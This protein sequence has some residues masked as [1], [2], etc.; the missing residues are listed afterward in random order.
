VVAHS[1]TTP[2]GANAP[3]FWGAWTGYRY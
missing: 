1:D 2:S 3:G